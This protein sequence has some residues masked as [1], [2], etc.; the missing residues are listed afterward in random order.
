VIFSIQQGS[1]PTRLG[2]ARRPQRGKPAR[3]VQMDEPGRCR[4]CDPIGRS[5]AIYRKTRRRTTTWREEMADQVVTKTVLTRFS[6]AQTDFQIALDAANAALSVSSN[7]AISNLVRAVGYYSRSTA[8]SLIA[9]SEQLDD[10]N[11][12]INNVAARLDGKQ[13]PFSLKIR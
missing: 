10:I 8:D 5:G 3:E 1:A 12:N 13:G 9:I 11:R 4:R 2:L 7:P 6:A